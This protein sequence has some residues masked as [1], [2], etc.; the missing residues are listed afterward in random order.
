MPV[1]SR[2]LNM[3]NVTL[4]AVF[5]VVALVVCAAALGGTGSRLRQALA[6]PSSDFHV[7]ALTLGVRGGLLGGI[8]LVFLTQG[9]TRL[10]PFSAGA[11]SAGLSIPESLYLS[12]LATTTL[13]ARHP[14]AKCLLVGGCLAAVTVSCGL[15]FSLAALVLPGLAPAFETPRCAVDGGVRT[16]RCRAK[17][18]C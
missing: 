11:W 15:G 18:P 12:A 17:R 13:L 8:C 4:Q 2:E 6:A 10:L 3:P 14:I 1:V 9:S 5:S 16:P 7:Q